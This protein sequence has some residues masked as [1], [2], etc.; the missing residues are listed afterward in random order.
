MAAEK[1]LKMVTVDQ[2]ADMLG[3]NRMTVYRRISDGEIP[4]TNIGRKGGRA[5]LR[6]HVSDLIAY[7]Q[8]G[9][10]PVPSRRRAVA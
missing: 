1:S 2:A 9:A 6:I 4:A 3:V 7:Q 5:R 8:A 10:V